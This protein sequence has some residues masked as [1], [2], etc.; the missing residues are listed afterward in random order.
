MTTD[1]RQKIIKKAM[2]HAQNIIKES[3]QLYA[4]LCELL[5][6]E[7]DLSKIRLASGSVGTAV[8]NIYFDLKKA[9]K[10]SK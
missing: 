8:E 5:A 10:D 6:E 1:E 9:L 3:N 7:D 2:G 4:W